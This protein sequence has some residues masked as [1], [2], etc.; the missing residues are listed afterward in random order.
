MG[1]LIIRG[2]LILMGVLLLGS[3]SQKKE[4]DKTTDLK[5]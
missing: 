3:C 4:V 2:S 5:E 1:N